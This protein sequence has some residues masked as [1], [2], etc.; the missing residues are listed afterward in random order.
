MNN[1]RTLCVGLF[2][3]IV[4]RPWYISRSLARS[5]SLSLSLFRSLLIMQLQFYM[6]QAYAVHRRNRSTEGV[7]T[8][9]VCHDRLDF[10]G[11]GICK[12]GNDD[13]ATDVTLY[14]YLSRSSPSAGETY[15]R[16]AFSSDERFDYVIRRLSRYCERPEAYRLSCTSEKLQ[17]FRVRV[18]L[19]GDKFP[20]DLEGRS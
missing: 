9:N 6:P 3:I 12:K 11:N 7:A 17:R 15:F 19:L 5:I 4:N 20:N 8:T 14:I 13:N 1:L 16:G 10:T 18:L 2:R